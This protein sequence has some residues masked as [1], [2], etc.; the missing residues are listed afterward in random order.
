M[1]EKVNATRMELL[2]LKKRLQLAV[3]GHKLL[4]D[5][6]DELM[7]L[8]LEIIDEVKDLRLSVESQFRSILEGFVLAKAARGPFQVEQAL[9]MPTKKISVSVSR[10]NLM[11][12]RVPEYT[13]E[14]SGQII[15]YGYLN[16]SGDIDIS[17]DKFDK[18]IE[19]L[20]TLAEKEK[21]VQLMATEIEETRRRV[22]A[23]EYK[24]IP[25]LE[26]TIKFITM[27]LDEN[28]RSNTVRLMKVKD[29]V[30]SH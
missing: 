30:R 5:K 28:E 24:L 12:V 19:S 10:K 25:N 2:R 11:S 3:R 27:K 21:A 26:E 13:R 8:L 17:L 18:F 23:L 29:I 1:L 6:R 9:L 15:P 4:K 20:L 14:V 7:R 16:T 22:N